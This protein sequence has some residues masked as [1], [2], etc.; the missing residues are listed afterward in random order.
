MPELPSAEVVAACRRLADSWTDFDPVPLDAPDDEWHTAAVPFGEARLA[1]EQLV[2]PKREPI[3][4]VCARLI[5]AYADRIE[6]LEKVAEAAERHA[7]WCGSW[8]SPSLSSNPAEP[9]LPPRCGAC[10]WCT[11]RSALDAL[12]PAVIEEPMLGG[13][14]A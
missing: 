13:D 12:T 10:D 8:P 7:G 11:L 6:A 3:E 1:F 4:A 5:V 9:S 14:G 2:N